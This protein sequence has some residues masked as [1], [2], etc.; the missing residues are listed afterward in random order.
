MRTRTGPITESLP[1]TS[2][3]SA[4]I[5]AAAISAELPTHTRFV[6][7]QAGAKDRPDLPELAALAK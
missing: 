4:P 5:E 3:A 6:E 1:A 7:L 2:S